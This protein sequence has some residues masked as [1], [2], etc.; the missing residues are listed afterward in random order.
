MLPE[1]PAQLTRDNMAIANKLSSAQALPT[2]IAPRGEAVEKTTWELF[3]QQ[4]APARALEIGQCLRPVRNAGLERRL[5]ASESDS[6]GD[7]WAAGA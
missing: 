4:I 7:E 3:P 1:Q 6:Q 2:S 5:K